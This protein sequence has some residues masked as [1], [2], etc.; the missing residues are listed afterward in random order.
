MLV[1]IVRRLLILPIIL[2]GVTV[3]I[4]GFFSFLD[5]AMRASLYVE[6]VPKGPDALQRI[7]K[8]YGLDDP[9]HIQYWR[10]INQIVRGNFGWSQTAQRPVLEALGHYFPATLELALWAMVPVIFIGIWLGILSALHHNRMVDH[11]TRVVALVGWSFPS[12]VYGLLLLMVFYAMLRWFPPGRISDW[13]IREVNAGTF[14]QYTG[15]YTLDAVLNG[16]PDVFGNALRHL[17]MPV[18]TL[19]YIQWALLLRVTRSSMLETLRQEYVMTARAKGLKER[20]VVYKHAARNAMIP[21]ATMGGLLL[22]G[23]LNGV[24]ITETVFNYPGLGRWAV[25]AATQF[26]IL[27]VLGFTLFNS[28]LFV[29]GNLAV[30]V[31]YAVI[32]PRIRLE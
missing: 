20:V 1:F 29:F 15:L 7:I 16:R 21:V 5:P 32:D 25:T 8:K 12:F 4:F 26:D 19:S 27:G 30:D 18:I 24:V 31:L 17:V 13:V 3:F 11:T 2:F 22:I 23:L 14:V 28:V 9:I 10:W 6:D